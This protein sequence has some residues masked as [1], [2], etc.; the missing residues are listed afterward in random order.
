MPPETPTV[1][2][3]VHRWQST[4]STHSN[5]LDD[6]TESEITITTPTRAQPPAR[7]PRSAAR[8]KEAGVVRKVSL[9]Y[10]QQCGGP[11]AVVAGMDGKGREKEKKSGG[12]RKQHVR[13]TSLQFEKLAKGQTG[14][15][16]EP[17]PTAA[18]SPKRP[19]LRR[20]T[21]SKPIIAA[22]DDDL[23]IEHL[24]RPVSPAG[25]T[26]FLA[27]AGN[28]F[29]DEPEEMDITSQPLLQS[30]TPNS[31]N[32]FLDAHSVSPDIGADTYGYVNTIS[33]K[34]ASVMTSGSDKL[35]WVSTVSTKPASPGMDSP[36]S[37]P[38]IVVRA[39]T[40]RV[41]RKPVTV[42]HRPR[43]HVPF[44]SEKVTE[45]TSK[46]EWSPS[47]S[48]PIE[49]QVNQTLGG[50]PRAVSAA[51][52]RAQRQWDTLHRAQDAGLLTPETPRTRKAS[53]YFGEGGGGV[54]TSMHLQPYQPM[55]SADVGLL[56]PQLVES[57]R[58]V[59]P[60]D[61]EYF[62]FSGQN[63][64]LQR[65]KNEPFP[66]VS[67]DQD[68][69]LYIPHTLHVKHGDNPAK[70]EHKRD[71][72]VLGKEN[73]RKGSV[74]A[75]LFGR[76]ALPIQLPKLDKFIESLPATEFSPLEKVLDDTQYADYE[77]K[78][79]AEFP[80]MH[81]IPNNITLDDLKSNVTKRGW[82][83]TS[84][85]NDI[86]GVLADAFIGAEGSTLS[87]YVTLEIFRDFIQLMALVFSGGGKDSTVLNILSLN[88][89]DAFGG[90]SIFLGL[91]LLIAL[92]L[93][94]KFMRIRRNDPN[95]HTEG[96][97]S[98]PWTL[99][100]KKKRLGNIITIFFLTTLYL[101]V[102]KL[103]VDA[104]VWQKTFWPTWDAERAAADPTGYIQS[105]N[106]CYITS[107]R[108]KD[109]NWVYLVLPV[110]FI[111]VCSIGIYMPYTL[112]GVVKR[113]VP[114]VDP[115][116]EAGELRTDDR[117]EYVRLLDR[118]PS[119]YNFMYS[120]YR[121]EWA[122]YK[123][124]V[125]LTKLFYIL[126]IDVVSVNNCLFRH[127]DAKLIKTISAGMQ[128]AFM[129]VLLGIHVATMVLDRPFFLK[130]QQNMSE[131][132]TRCGYVLTTMFVLLEALNLGAVALF[133]YL[134]Y[135]VSMV[136]YVF[137]GYYALSGV[138]FFDTLVKR[139][140]NRVDVS[141]ERIFCSR[142][143]FPRQIKRRIWMDT[144]TAMLLCEDRT[145]M[146]EDEIVAF[147]QAASHPPYMLQFHGTAA[148][149]HVENLKLTRTIGLKAYK[150]A[151]EPLA[152]ETIALRRK[153]YNE[154]VGPDCFYT[155][156]QP[157]RGKGVTTWFG[158][159]YVAP[160][161]FTVVLVYDEVPISVS[162]SEPWEIQRYVEQN[163]DREVKRRRRVRQ[164]I[165]AL[166]GQTVYR[167]YVKMPQFDMENITSR[168]KGKQSYAK[169]NEA[170]QYSEGILRIQHRRQDL[171]H[172]KNMNA[173]F[174]VTITYSTT[175][176]GRFRKKSKER[177]K[178][179]GE[180]IGVTSDFRLTPALES[181]FINN[182][183]T[184]ERGLT[185]WLDTLRSYADYWRNEALQKERI[186]SYAFQMNVFNTPTIRY[187]QLPKVLEETE[188]DPIILDLPEWSKPSLIYLYERLR[189]VNRSRLHQWW[190]LFWDDFWRRNYVALRS[191]KLF[192]MDFSPTSPTSICYTPMPREKLEVFLRSRGL[193]KGR[194][195]PRAFHDGLLNRI[196]LRCEAIVYGYGEISESKMISVSESM[197]AN[198]ISIGNTPIIR[199]KLTPPKRI[200]LSRMFSRDSAS[201][202]TVVGDIEMGTLHDIPE[203]DER[204]GLTTPVSTAVSSPKTSSVTASKVEEVRDVL[205]HSMDEGK[206]LEDVHPEDGDSGDSDSEELYF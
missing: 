75:S 13:R 153:I 142:L 122:A 164:M 149:R 123:I 121:R 18:D 159:A 191:L 10:E 133:T 86:I 19:H 126:L 167:P 192:E 89:Q 158:K 99:Q 166:D 92:L 107:A 193:W 113:N 152:A 198:R 130:F 65:T 87:V 53:E 174:D 9:Q 42:A 201:T 60:A 38:R 88:L 28:P 124:Y 17:Q 186:L 24:S 150:A 63:V 51:N 157:W 6:R 74:Q 143:K 104:L 73:F 56:T 154:F 169:I 58:E 204:K 141:I 64:P 61:E 109:I 47:A 33:T 108:I 171:W 184:L 15:I 114:R 180:L 36:P 103:A 91:F 112:T 25:P 194:W 206:K 50:F 98:N 148:E 111:A 178:I 181:L 71:R 128:I 8:I 23:P 39:A 68:Q 105:N 31:R 79:R 165:R 116:N 37:V 11:S 26:S 22:H 67:V 12:H 119:P 139:F 95:I 1:K 132:A 144:W 173:G 32:P 97:E 102:M 34:P 145:R 175:E 45:D 16:E 40:N 29:A 85:Q 147:S 138:Q 118:D 129:L 205:L 35:G 76:E 80:P 135:S 5:A 176:T 7:Y 30:P 2:D 49:G 136:I 69:S 59:S 72:I 77:A 188:V 187:P 131:L 172:E 202:A 189:V 4:S 57:V 43:A 27:E 155:P 41:P 146:P 117:E 14:P 156:P 55:G 183:S 100:R 110:A 185:D 199:V 66:E 137:I 93:L 78:G 134:S 82:L 115:Y 163:E 44:Y 120:S 84:L 94:W 96:F 190:Y 197:A 170:L 62:K 182:R 179:S 3:L 162:L 203:E 83:G 151:C 52:N 127:A 106:V 81:L 20:T 125:L 160:F 140:S 54:E 196:Y 70:A 195:T 177:V 21:A 200:P 90:G 48:G 161:P 46:K 101:P 168:L